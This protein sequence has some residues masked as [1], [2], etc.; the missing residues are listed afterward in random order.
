MEIEDIVGHKFN[1]LNDT[2][3]QIKWKGFKQ[4]YDEWRG[5]YDLIGND[6]HTQY[7]IKNNIV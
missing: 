7:C 2:I 4:G 3:F 5:N 1:F 6:I